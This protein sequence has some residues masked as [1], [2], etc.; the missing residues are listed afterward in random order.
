MLLINVKF[1]EEYKKLDALCKDVLGSETGVTEYINQMDMT[2][3]SDQALVSSWR[4]DYKNLKH[5]RWVR[6]KLAHEVGALDE[7][8]C[9]ENDIDWLI[10]FSKRIKKGRDPFSIIHLSKKDKK[11][12]SSAKKSQPTKKADKKNDESSS[13]W[14]RFING[15]KNLLKL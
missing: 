11:S 4:E 6:N 2:S 9:N 14:T 1:Q 3:P 8:L 7:V 12:K 5:Y 15:F 10:D 13:L